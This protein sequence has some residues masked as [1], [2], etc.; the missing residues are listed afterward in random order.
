MVENGRFIREKLVVRNNPADPRQKAFQ[1]PVLQFDEPAKLGFSKEG[2]ARLERVIAEEIARDTMPGAVVMIG[3]YGKIAFLRSFGVQDPRR[4]RDMRTD[5]IF[6]IFSMTKPVT[7][8]AAMALVEEGRISLDDLL[9]KYIPEFGDVP[10]AR[11]SRNRMTLIRPKRQMT[12]HD[13]LRHTSGL[14]HELINSPLQRSYLKNELARRDRTNQQHARIVAS[15]PLLCHPGEEWNYSRSVEILGRVIEVASG[16]SLGAFLAERI[17]LPLGMHD[18]GFHVDEDKGRD[19]LAEPAE[20]DPWTGKPIKLF[21]MLEKP[22]FEAG[23][24]GLVSTAPDYARFAQMLLNEGTLDGTRIIGSRTLRF[25]TADHLPQPVKINGGLVPPGFGFGLGFA[26]RTQIGTAPFPGSVGQYFWN[27]SAG[28]QFWVDPAEH[29]WA[30]L[31]VQAPGQRDHL[32][33]LIRTLVYAALA[34]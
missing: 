33:V 10:V 2:I 14:S 20:R 30:L 17:L 8:V 22:L 21:D 18:T 16:Q 13:L 31:M 26:V 23:G 4:G 25:M 6:R 1:R 15:L 5:S 27:G 29:L 9:A 32:R 34:D 28:T 19:R 7:S 24:G 3:R 12:L 11:F